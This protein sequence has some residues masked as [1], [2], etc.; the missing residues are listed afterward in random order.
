MGKRAASV[1]I[2]E[3]SLAPGIAVKLLREQCEKGR[4]LIET[5]I[6]P[7]S[8]DAWE[9]SAEDLLI[10]AFGNVSP[11]ISKVMNHYKM[12]HIG[13]GNEAEFAKERTTR[14]RGRIEI[15]EG[16]VELLESQI[17]LETT[18]TVVATPVSDQNTAL[19]R[20]VFLVHGHNEAVLNATARFLQGLDLKVVVLS[21]QSN[22][23]RTIIEK[24]EKHS[25]VGFA[26]V[27]LTGDDRGG[28]SDT[29]YDRQKPRARQNVILELGYFLG[30]LR[31]NRVCVL[32]QEGVEI[33]SDY[34]GVV[35]V[36]L[37]TEGAWKFKLA[38]EIK[39]AGIDVDMN[40]AVLG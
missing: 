6:T 18:G 27:L 11:N 30:T 9:A 7:A 35:Y 13:G 36:K 38:K 33:P 25:E 32:V 12:F 3:A 29:P 34:H 23:G 37:D 28:S 26:V 16:L 1:H 24:F 4:K 21:E 10:K 17:R 31:R 14:M 15:I 40:L 20:T 22:E 8:E 39:A 19:P 5:G 2:V